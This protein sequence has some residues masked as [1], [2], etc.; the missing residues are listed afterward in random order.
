[1]PGC[2]DGGVHAC[3]SMSACELRIKEQPRGDLAAVV[4]EGSWL[5]EDATLPP[6][7][8]ERS[9]GG[10]SRPALPKSK[11]GL[12]RARGTPA[13]CGQAQPSI[14]HSPAGRSPSGPVF[15]SQEPLESQTPP[16]PLPGAAATSLC[17]K[18]TVVLFFFFI[19]IIYKDGSSKKAESRRPGW[20]GAGFV[21]SPQGGTW[22]PTPSLLTP[23]PPT[24]PKSSQSPHHSLLH[25][26]GDPSRRKKVT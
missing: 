18:S 11:V 13:T 24:K 22:R 12:P 4:A 19:N 14:Q 25:A 15:P 20:V 3:A 6:P 1:M 21:P 17:S 10:H 9:Q 23:T 5:T 8:A 7:R 2:G 16:L 26:Q